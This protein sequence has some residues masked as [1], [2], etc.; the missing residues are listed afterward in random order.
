[1]LFIGSSRRAVSVE[2]R[3][4]AAVWWAAVWF[5]TVAAG[6]AAMLAYEFSPGAARAAPPRLPPAGAAAP[7]SGRAHLEVFLHPQCPC[8]RATVAALT[9]IVERATGSFDCVVTFLAPVERPEWRGA[10]LVLAVGALPGV[11]VRYEDDEAAFARFG[12]RTSGHAVLYDAS[13]ALIFEGGLTASRGQ[14]GA[15][16]GADLVAAFLAGTP[17]ERGSAPVFGCPL[18]DGACVDARTDVT[19]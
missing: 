15:A 7:S 11:E 5:M 18:F 8:S 10:P 6:T 13:G 3:G 1:M 9:K 12:A 4:T 17:T 2:Q 16:P 14:E 19:R